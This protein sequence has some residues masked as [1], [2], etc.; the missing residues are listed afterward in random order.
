MRHEI[1][2]EADHERVCRFKL[3]S[4]SRSLSNGQKKAAGLADAVR[5]WDGKLYV[6]ADPWEDGDGSWYGFLRIG[7]GGAEVLYC[8]EAAYSTITDFAFSS[9]GTLWFIQRNLFLGSTGLNRLDTETGEPAR[10]TDLSETP[11]ACWT[12][13]PSGKSRSRGPPRN[14][15]FDIRTPFLR[16]T[17]PIAAAACPPAGGRRP[18]TAPR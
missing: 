3:R 4:I 7:G 16:G 13:T 8:T 6:L 12:L 18:R 1:L 15:F 9:D 11:S 2:A 17:A 14:G 10:V 5:A